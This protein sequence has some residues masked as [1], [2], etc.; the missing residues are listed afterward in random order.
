MILTYL[1]LFRTETDATIISTLKRKGW[2]EAR[3]DVRL[4]P[5]DDPRVADGYPVGY[6]DSAKPLA[7]GAEA[8]HDEMSQAELAALKATHAEALA[9]Y[10]A[11]PIP[12]R[13]SKDTL[14]SRV[15]E[16]GKLP[17]VMAALAAQSEEQQFVFSQS[18]WFWSSNA[19]LRGLC[20]SPSIGLDADA[21]LA[22]DPYL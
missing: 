21:I 1:D 2:T 7:V 17:E 10:L 6:P 20:A 19:T 18:A 15:L 11:R 13:V 5:A 16:A 9:S 12:W 22:R 8:E 3:M 14:I 4:C